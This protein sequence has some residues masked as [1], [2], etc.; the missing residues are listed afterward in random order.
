MN[1]YLK[2]TLLFILLIHNRVY[3]QNELS[4]KQALML[5]QKQSLDAFSSQHSFLSSYWE[6][7]SY[8]S[9]QLPYLSLYIN[10]IDYTQEMTERYNYDNNI[11]TYRQQQTLSSY[12]VLNLTQNIAKTGTRFY[13][14][15]DIYRLQNLNI[16]DGVSW[17]TTPFKIGITQP[18]GDF[19]SYKWQKKIYPL[20]YEKAKRDYIQSV[21][22]INCKVIELYFDYL[23]AHSNKEIASTNVATADTLYK[24]GKNRF[25]IA[26]ILQEELLDLELNVFNSRVK[27]AK[28]KKEE[29]EA[30]FNLITLLGTK[31]NQKINPVIPNIYSDIIIDENLAIEHACQLN[32]KVIQLKQKEV[33]ATKLLEQTIKESSFSAKFDISYGFNQ[34]TQNFNSAYKNPLSQQVVSFSAT[35]PLFDWGAA[36]EERY[37]AKHKKAISDTEIKQAQ[38]DFEQEIRLTVREF[39]LQKHVVLNAAKADSLAQHSYE[40]TKQKF[41]KGDTDVLKLTNARNNRQSAQEDY[42]ESLYYYW[43]YFYTIQELTLFDFV[44]QKAL[45]ENFDLLIKEMY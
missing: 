42:I 14:E 36:R 17:T 1:K 23:L 12:S 28:A 6:F 35:I 19:N 37:K 8:K 13:V 16:Q 45:E 10:P 11:V 29:D 4:M 43:K 15:S 34:T 26:S 25:E 5:A 44:N 41:I 20:K 22:T 9:G 40:R 21:Q 18:I 31:N 32:P 7:Q 39:N 3:S 38:L 30:C 27:L 33:E 24:I 2:I